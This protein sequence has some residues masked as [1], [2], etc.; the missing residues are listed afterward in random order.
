MDAAVVLARTLLLL[1]DEVTEKASDNDLIT[2]L[3]ATTIALVP[4]P[5]TLRSHA[6]QTAL[7][8]AA[9]LCARSGHLVF[10]VVPEHALVGLQPPIARGAIGQAFSDFGEHLGMAPRI[11][12]GKPKVRV[13]MQVLFGAAV[14]VVDSNRTISVAADAWSATLNEGSG[15]TQPIVES[16]PLGAMAAGALAAGEVFKC[17]ARKMRH[18]ARAHS[19]FDSL[20]AECVDARIELAPPH[21]GT[22]SALSTCDVISAGA[23]SN[24]ALYAFLRIPGISGVIRVLDDDLAEASNLNRYALLETSGLGTQKAPYL[25]RFSI[26][27]FVVR[28]SVGRFGADDNSQ[29]APVVLIG[30]DDIAARWNVQRRLPTWLSVAATSH[31]SAMASYHEAH[32]PC[33]GCLHPHDDLGDAPIPTVAFVSFWAGLL[34]AVY[35]LRHLAGAPTPL[36]E[37]QTFFSPLRPESIWKSAVA[38]H[39]RCPVGHG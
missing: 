33:A 35:T 27:D 2:A 13:D 7:A 34:Q 23:I 24:T 22:T 3:T 1:R 10:L 17:A 5:H 30:T 31:W 16:W 8:T 26:D 19:Y 32:T 25:E 38:F 37:Q 20:F 6:G 9:S 11:I 36:S 21:T 14:P 39:P 4:C 12:Y 18:A 29:F 28:G 15:A